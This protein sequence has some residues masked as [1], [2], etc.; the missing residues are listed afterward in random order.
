MPQPDRPDEVPE[1][2]LGVIPDYVTSSSEEEDDD[3]SS[4]PWEEMKNSPE[5][6]PRAHRED[7]SETSSVLGG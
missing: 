6:A 4:R 1:L 2:D 5:K 3:E 7:A